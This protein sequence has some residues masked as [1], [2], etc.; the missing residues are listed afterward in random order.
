MTHDEHAEVAD[1][2]RAAKSTFYQTIQDAHAG[3][4]AVPRIISLVGFSNARYSLGDE[5][6]RPY[7]ND[8]PRPRTPKPRP[9][10]PRVPGATPAL[11]ASIARRAD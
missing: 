6:V 4:L 2:I 5:A 10:A 3:G 9:L 11:M 8:G 1:A 7:A